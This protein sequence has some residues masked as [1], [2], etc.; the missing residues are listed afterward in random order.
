MEIGRRGGQRD[1]WE[2]NFVQA[3][4]TL[5]ALFSLLQGVCR[6]TGSLTSPDL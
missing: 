1:R 5:E 6:F 3:G 2:M 4:R